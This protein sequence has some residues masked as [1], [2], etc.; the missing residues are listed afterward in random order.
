ML[1]GRRTAIFRGSKKLCSVENPSVSSEATALKMSL[2]MTPREFT[3]LL[4]SSMTCLQTKSSR[5]LLNRL[6]SLRMRKKPSFSNSKK[7]RLKLVPP[8]MLNWTR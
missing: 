2:F 5:P 1:L 3:L 8:L 4:E 6:P 7:F